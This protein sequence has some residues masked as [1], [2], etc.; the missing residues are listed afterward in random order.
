MAELVDKADA[1]RSLLESTAAETDRLRHLPD[2]NVQ[3]LKNT[4]LCRLMVPK[5]FGGYQTNIHTYIEVMEALGR[6]CGST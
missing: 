3:A 1:L 6:G 4:G 5:R 2:A